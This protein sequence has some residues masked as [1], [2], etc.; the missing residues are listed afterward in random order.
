MI[1]EN[2][3]FALGS[4]ATALVVLSAWQCAGLY[5]QPVTHPE[6]AH[7]HE[8][9][10]NQHALYVDGPTQDMFIK[11]LTNP[12]KY[13]VDHILRDEETVTPIGELK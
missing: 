9:W 6:D 10:L 4:L 12:K 1:P 8:L 3:A 2:K 5:P 7:I 11:T 13:H